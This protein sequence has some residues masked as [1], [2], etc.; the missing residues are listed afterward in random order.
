VAANREIAPLNIGSKD[1]FRAKKRDD[2]I[3]TRIVGEVDV[4]FT[5]FCDT[6]P[7]Q[8]GDADP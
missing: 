1:K 3:E 5:T 8:S 2:R 6:G 4:I 7:Q